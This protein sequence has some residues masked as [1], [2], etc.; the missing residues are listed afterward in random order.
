M[1]CHCKI[2]LVS[3]V[4]NN[5][6]GSHHL[7]CIYAECSHMLVCVG[8]KGP[9]FCE[10]FL[11]HQIRICFLPQRDGSMLRWIHHEGHQYFEIT[12]VLKVL[13]RILISFKLR[14]TFLYQPFFYLA[15]NI[16][17]E[18]SIGNI[19]SIIFTRGC[20]ITF[21]V[22]RVLG[23]ISFACTTQRSRVSYRSKIK[24]DRNNP[25]LWQVVFILF[26]LYNDSLL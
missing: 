17:N 5:L 18:I 14:Y 2:L 8:S 19:Q 4:C 3:Q 20:K 23:L 9:Y 26:F 12:L 10:W 25:N 7:F 22:L 15:S 1:I 24:L 21:R 13:N 11:I 6:I 16:R